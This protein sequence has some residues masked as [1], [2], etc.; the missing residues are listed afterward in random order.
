MDKV[1]QAYKLHLDVCV[2][3]CVSGSGWGGGEVFGSVH[4]PAHGL[5][6]LPQL[7]QFARRD[8]PTDRLCI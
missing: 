2:C 1:K 6:L 3:V 4:R 5:A 8:Q 7:R